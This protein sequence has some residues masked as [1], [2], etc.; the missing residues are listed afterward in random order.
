MEILTELWPTFK[1]ILIGVL[2]WIFTASLSACGVKVGNSAVIGTTG[3]L[4]QVNAGRAM[5]APPE[6]TETEKRKLEDVIR[7]Y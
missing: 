3:F 6:H 4:E 7:R 1:I 2:A 5:M